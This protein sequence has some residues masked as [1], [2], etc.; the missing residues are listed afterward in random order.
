MK[1]SKLTYWFALFQRNSFWMKI[2]RFRK[3]ISI[4]RRNDEIQTTRS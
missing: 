4:P 3:D 1:E 2:Q